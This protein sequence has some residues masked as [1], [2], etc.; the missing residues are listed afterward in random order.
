MSVFHNSFTPEGATPTQ[1]QIIAEFTANNSTTTQK[2]QITGW[3]TPNYAAGASRTI[4]T[5]Y[6]AATDLWMYGSTKND[7]QGKN[8]A[9]ETA[10]IVGGVEV[11][12]IK[13]FWYDISSLMLFVKKGQTYQFK[14]ITEGFNN[15]KTFKIYP[16]K[17]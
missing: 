9:T 17:Y 1:K 11:G 5:V 10:F 16:C 14:T 2:Q 8:A 7:E 15:S 6:T 12:R 13:T 3:G 4:D